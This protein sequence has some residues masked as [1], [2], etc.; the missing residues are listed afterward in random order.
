MNLSKPQVD[1]VFVYTFRYC[2]GRRT[3]APTDCADLLI[4]H[5]ANI[6]EGSR[7]IIQ[8]ELEQAFTEDD[9]ARALGSSYKPLGDLCDRREWERVRKL[10]NADQSANLS[11]A[12]AALDAVREYQQAWLEHGTD[13]VHLFYETTDDSIA[14]DEALF[15]ADD[16]A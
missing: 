5:W 6:S 2:L 10:W 16:E 7:K 13:R 9:R 4:E 14:A 12:K 3:S 1:F 11:E 8:R 15:W